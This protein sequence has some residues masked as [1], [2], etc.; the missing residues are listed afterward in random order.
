[1]AA[2][3]VGAGEALSTQRLRIE[4]HLNLAL[5]AAVRKRDD[6]TGHGGRRSAG[7]VR[8]KVEDLRFGQCRA[9]KREL[10]DRYGG[11]VVSDNVGRRAARRQTFQQRLRNARDLGVRQLLIDVGLSG[12]GTLRRG[13]HW[14]WRPSPNCRNS[15]FLRPAKTSVSS[16]LPLPRSDS[17]GPSRWRH[18][19]FR[20]GRSSRNPTW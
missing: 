10:D 8:P 14:I 5:L 17:P 12:A 6:C 16:T 4:V 20:R 19:I 18:L 15:T 3:H 2:G 9:G 11:R 1:M 7:N 13:A